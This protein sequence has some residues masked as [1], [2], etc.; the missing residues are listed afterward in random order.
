M[1]ILIK[2]KVQ[3][4]IDYLISMKINLIVKLRRKHPKKFIQIISLI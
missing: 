1:R 4:K 3:M 2:N